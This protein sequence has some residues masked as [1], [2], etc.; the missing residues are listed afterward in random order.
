MS[1]L[2]ISLPNSVR[3][4]LEDLA[5]EDS[6]PLDDFVAATL[7][8]RAAIAEADSYIRLRARR[9]SPEQLAALLARA[10]DVPPEER[11]RVE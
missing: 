11:D 4:R 10:P 3:R 7:T 8:Q 9:G 6:V 1:T 2:S 5:R